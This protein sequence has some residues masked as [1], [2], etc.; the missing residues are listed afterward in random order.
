MKWL[1]KLWDKLGEEKFSS[2]AITIG[3]TLLNLF[4]IWTEQPAPEFVWIMGALNGGLILAQL[5]AEWDD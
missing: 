4:V 1:I 2:R 5:L 3:I